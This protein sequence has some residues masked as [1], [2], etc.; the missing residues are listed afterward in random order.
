MRLVDHPR[1]EVTRAA[2][3]YPLRHPVR[4]LDGGLL[5]AH[6]GA[7]GAACFRRRVRAVL[8]HLVA[9]GCATFERLGERV[10]IAVAGDVLTALFRAPESTPDSRVSEV[11]CAAA[12]RRLYR[13]VDAFDQRLGSGFMLRVSGARLAHGARPSV[14]WVVRR[15]PARSW[16]ALY[17]APRAHRRSRCRSPG[18]RP[19]TG[20]NWRMRATVSTSCDSLV[21]TSCDSLVGMR[22]FSRHCMRQFQ[23]HATV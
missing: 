18:S 23:P 10:G 9:R 21:G 4:C 19:R 3:R 14:P 6:C 7:S 2:S 11:V 15:L 16:A 22:Q 20:E 17:A 12:R 5:R 8:Y 13:C 1:A